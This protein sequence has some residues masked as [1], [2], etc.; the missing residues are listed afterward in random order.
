MAKTG[1]IAESPDQVTRMGEA[2]VGLNRRL[3][4]QPLT[5]AHEAPTRTPHFLPSIHRGEEIVTLRHAM[6]FGVVDGD[7]SSFRRTGRIF[8]G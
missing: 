4:Q 5:K 6:Q 8:T 3:G 2:A 7:R 1:P